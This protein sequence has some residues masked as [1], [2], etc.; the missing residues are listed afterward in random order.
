MMLDTIVQALQARSDLK[1]WSI[2][3]INKR[4]VQQYEMP[5]VTEA[6]REASGE[7]YK[8]MVLRE[9][10][11]A[12]GNPSCGEGVV[13]LLPGEDPIPALDKAALIAGMVHNPPYSLPTKHPVP[14]VELTDPALKADAGKELAAAL[15]ELQDTSAAFPHVRLTAAECFADE[16]SVH[17]VNSNGMEAEQAGT[18]VH[19][20]WV[21]IAGEDGEEVET[22]VELERRRFADLDLKHEVS[23]RAQYTTDLLKAD[24]APMYEGP[25]I[26][27]DG[28][29]ATVFDSQVF[30]VLSSASFKYSGETPWEIGKPIFKGESR[31]DVINLYANRMLPFGTRSNRVDASGVPAQRIPLI[32]D[33][34]LAAYTASQ[35]YADYLDIPATGAFGN[36]ELEA[37][38]QSATELLAGDYVEA[39]EFSW[40]NA[41]PI[42]GD[43][44]CEMRLGYMV[45]DG[46]RTPFKGGMLVGNVLEMLA[47]AHLSSETGFYGYYAGPTTARFN[48][49]KVAGHG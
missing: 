2:Q 35:Q 9:T 46:V 45:K 12:E 49:L 34:L 3:Q 21:F 31:G 19:L 47:D 43:F 1:G 33:N 30:K 29:L 22:F 25:V 42:S 27:R 38:S 23:R 37:G 11:D 10:P 26:I 24:P 36:I 5:A 14:A 17:F 13:T 20:E 6:L 39:A 7:Q 16:Q 18:L 8:V 40:F 48:Q 32:K 15:Q 4:G 41:N 44:A 28:T